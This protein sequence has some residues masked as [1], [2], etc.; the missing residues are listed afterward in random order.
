MHNLI[1][2]DYNKGINKS[3]HTMAYKITETKVNKRGIKYGL[4]QNEAGL[5]GVYKLCENY[6]SAAQKTG[7]TLTWRYVEKDMTK[8][9][10]AVLYTRRSK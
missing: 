7:T 8:E 5:F 9:A 3:L 4:A 1:K 2:I 10:A 6:C